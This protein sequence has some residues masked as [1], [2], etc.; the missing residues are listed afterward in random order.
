MRADKAKRCA[1]R[2]DILGWLQTVCPRI[3]HLPFCELHHY[4]VETRHE[5]ESG[6]EAPR[7]HAKTALG[8]SGIPL[9]QALEEPTLY[10]YVLNVQ[11]NE[12]KALAV[13]M[14]IRLELQQNPVL[15]Y[16]YG[17]QCG[18]DKWTDSLFVLK[19]GVAFQAA[20]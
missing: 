3:H 10:D 14:G 18:A 13:N 9:F 20:N 1:A 5:P 15:R 6:I 19:N 4:Q 12:K 16:L 11:A 2:K 7:F 17:D 8:C